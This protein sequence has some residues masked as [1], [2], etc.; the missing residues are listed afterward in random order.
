MSQQENVQI[1]KGQLQD[2]EQPIEIG[3][4]N[5]A[6]RAGVLW[7]EN[8]HLPEGMLPESL[9]SKEETVAAL[10]AELKQSQEQVVVEQ[11]DALYALA[12]GEQA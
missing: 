6:Y 9:P 5:S 3:A 1:I 12:L 2:L 4:L 8:Q 11:L 10:S 7:A